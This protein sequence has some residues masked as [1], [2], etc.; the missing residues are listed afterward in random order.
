MDEIHH[1]RKIVTNHGL[2]MQFSS[3][4]GDFFKNVVYICYDF[5]LICLLVLNLYIEIAW[6][7]F[8]FNS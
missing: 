6:L 4:S 7:L 8:L 1:F 2:E 5:S 3:E